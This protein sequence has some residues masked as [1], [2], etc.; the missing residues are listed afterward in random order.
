MSVYT[1]VDSS[2]TC[3]TE[4]LENHQSEFV[5]NSQMTHKKTTALYHQD[6]PLD[7]TQAMC[8]AMWAL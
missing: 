8:V 4:P 7:H 5:F 6:T 3:S 2:F 1:M